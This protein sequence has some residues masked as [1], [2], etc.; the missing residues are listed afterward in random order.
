M[1]MKNRECEEK[2]FRRMKLNRLKANKKVKSRSN[3]KSNQS[4]AE[5]CPIESIIGF[6]YAQLKNRINL[7]S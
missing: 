2:K 6:D 4:Q 1:N 5:L 3:Q 7:K